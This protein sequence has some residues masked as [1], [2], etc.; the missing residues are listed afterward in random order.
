MPWE[1]GKRLREIPPEELRRAREQLAK[2]FTILGKKAA[3][4]VGETT[5]EHLQTPEGQTLKG[6]VNTMDAETSGLFS[7]ALRIFFEKPPSK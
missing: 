5:A 3:R 1:H 7:R 6:I 2:E 4:A